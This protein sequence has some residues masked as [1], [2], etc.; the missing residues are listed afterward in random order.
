M[1]AL[2]GL[3]YTAVGILMLIP[4]LTVDHRNS[5]GFEGAVGAMGVLAIAMGA[6]VLIYNGI[7]WAQS[8]SRARAFADARPPDWLIPPPAAGEPE[9]IEP[10]RLPDGKDT[11]D[12]DKT[13]PRGF[14]R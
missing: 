3:G 6:P 7:V 1:L 14:S 13:P 11:E 9:P 10:L 8:K 12:P 2:I 5:N 4:A